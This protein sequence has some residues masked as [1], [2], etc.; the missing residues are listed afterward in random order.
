V[1]AGGSVA[2]L[3]VAM[4]A[5]L[6]E[7]AARLS[8][9]HWIGAANVAKRAAVLRKVATVLID[10]DVAAFNDYLKAVRAARGQ[11]TTRREAII[12]PARERIVEVPLAVVRS[13]AEV[14]ELAAEMAQHGNPNLRSD[15]Y[16]ALQLSAAAARS[17]A[18]TL[19]DN[20]RSARDPRLVEAKRL[21]ASA[22]A[23]ARRPLFQRRADARDR[24]RARARGSGRR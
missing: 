23:L 3:T 11:H 10:A 24:G 22:S 21:A 17:G 8:T 1:P 15:G 18:T 19:A 20:V 2:A 16:A 13:A 14:A 12:G 5:G 6:V 7:K 4:A 9:E